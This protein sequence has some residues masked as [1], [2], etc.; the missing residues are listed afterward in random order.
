MNYV[1]RNLLTHETCAE[2]EIEFMISKTTKW[3]IIPM[4]KENE[5]CSTQPTDT[6][7][8]CRKE[9]E[10]YSTQT[11]LSA[12]RNLCIKEN[13]LRS[14]QTSMWPTKLVLRRK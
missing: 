11:A 13:E 1:Q 5:L 9:K 4:H 7:N 6:R 3:H 8:L 10:L 2:K 12:T 14:V